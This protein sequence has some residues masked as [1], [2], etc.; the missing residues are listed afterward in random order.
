MGLILLGNLYVIFS[1]RET[2][3]KYEE[4]IQDIQN[5]TNIISDR[6]YDLDARFTADE[7]KLS[8]VRGEINE[9]TEKLGNTQQDIG[10]ASENLAATMRYINQLAEALSYEERLDIQEPEVAVEEAILTD[11]PAA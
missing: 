3:L 6:I 9:T 10:K 2:L 8:E 1:L 11:A 5:N 7:L 4:K